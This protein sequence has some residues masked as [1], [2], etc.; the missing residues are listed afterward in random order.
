M[1]IWS[2]TTSWRPPGDKRQNRDVLHR[3]AI[4][5]NFLNKS[6]NAGDPPGPPRGLGKTAKP[7][8]STPGVPQIAGFQSGG[9]CSNRPWRRATIR[10]SSQCHYH[11]SKGSRN[12]FVGQVFFGG[13]GCQGQTNT[14]FQENHVF[15]ALPP[16]AARP[17]NHSFL[18]HE[19]FLASV[20]QT[21][22]KHTWP[23]NHIGDMQPEPKQKLPN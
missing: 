13:L 11:F 10:G 17:Q 22:K 6:S 16:S 4:P 20:S 14:H 7:H 18:E 3:R 12:V 9:A 1:Q 19:W 23:Q 21:S 5:A 8:G 15:G 2:L